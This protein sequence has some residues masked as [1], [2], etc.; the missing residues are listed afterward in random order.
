MFRSWLRALALAL[1]TIMF[2][3]GSAGLFAPR[4]AVA[5]QEDE[6][7]YRQV[8]SEA[9]AEYDAHHFEEAR[10]LFRRAHDLSPNARTLRGIG[11]ASFELRDY[12]D[13]LRS[14]QGALTDQRR[15]LTP[16]QRAQVSGLIERTRAFV[17]QYMLPASVKPAVLRVD[18]MPATTEADGTLLLNFGRHAVT[19]ETPGY[20][21]ETRE[22]YV[23]G[24]ERQELS[25]QLRPIAVEPPAPEPTKTAATTATATQ[26]LGA[27]DAAPTAATGASETTPPLATQPEG[28]GARRGSR[29]AM[30]FVGAGVLAAGA[31]AT[32]LWWHNRNGEISLCQNAGA[33]CENED[34]LTGQRD[35]AIGLTAGMA[36][37]AAVLGIMGTVVLAKS[38]KADAAAPAMVACS[39]TPGAGNG[40][41]LGSVNCAIRYAF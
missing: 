6:A 23:I 10:A 21:P 33:N 40:S 19:V 17:G 12:V 22:L 38:H 25:F 3:A 26:H 29:T 34:Q 35:M 30:W 15:P 8:L 16:A 39:P 14:L 13:A 32:G 37:G 41:T 2:V 36:V 24:G 7:S 31:V 20:V 11:M 1:P 27:V 5:A 4:A 28:A 18:G 9:L